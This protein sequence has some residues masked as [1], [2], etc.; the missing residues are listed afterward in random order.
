MSFQQAF[1]DELL[2]LAGTFGPRN[3]K[4][5]R[6]SVPKLPVPKPRTSPMGYPSKLP[7]DVTPVAHQTAAT[8]T[9]QLK[10]IIGGKPGS[11]LPPH[12][13]HLSPKPHQTRAEDAGQLYELATGKK[14]PPGYPGP[15]VK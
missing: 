3:P 1:I 15:N 10:K 5:P 12:L 14:P 9:E 8:D 13:R 4:P 11:A 2:K 6:V 7:P